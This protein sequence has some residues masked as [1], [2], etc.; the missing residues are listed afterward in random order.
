[1]RYPRVVGSPDEF[2]ADWTAD[3][4]AGS[5]R[6]DPAPRGAAGKRPPSSSSGAV[7]DSVDSLVEGPGSRVG[8]YTL[9]KLLGEGGFG[10]VFLAEQEVPVRRTVA[11]KIIKLGMDTRQVVA[12]FEQ[13]RQAL[14]WMDHPNIAR[15][16]DA[17]ATATG[18]PFFVME[19]VKGEPIT[20]YC[21]RKKLSIPN[22]L[23][24]FMQ[25]CSAVQ[26][27]HTKGIIHRDLKPGN[28]LASTQ[29]GKP[30]AKVIDFGVAK[31]TSERVKSDAVQTEQR[32]LVGTPL[33]MSPEQAAGSADIDTRTDIYSLGVVLYE[34][35]TG[36]TPIDLRTLR[37]TG[38]AQ[39]EKLICEHDPPR[40]SSRV[41]GTARSERGSEHEPSRP[42]SLEEVAARRSVDT[43]RLHSLV[44]GE[45]DWIVLRAM[46]K[47]RS[48]RYE[49]AAALAADLRRHLAGEPIQAAPPSRRYRVSKFVRRHRGGVGAAAAALLALLLGL[50]G[51]VWQAYRASDERDRAI[52]AQEAEARERSVAEAQRRAADDALAVAESQRDKAERI[53]EFMSD[54]LRGAGPSA[55][56]GRDITMLKEMMDRSAARIDA[57]ALRGSPES[58][59]QLRWT[60]GVTYRELALHADASRMLAPALSLAR[61]LHP[62]DHDEIAE[63]LGEIGAL[64]QAQG[65][66]A[67]A[68][69]SF[70]ESLAMM[71]RLHLGDHEPSAEAMGRLGSVLQ[72]QGSLGDAEPL[73]RESLAMN[74]RLHE[75][76]HPSVARSLGRMSAWHRANRDLPTAEPLARAS[77]EMYQRLHPGDHPDVAE[78]LHTMA[79]QLQGGRGFESAERLY[80][81]SLEMYRRLFDGDH[82]LIARGLNSLAFALQSR[83]DLVGSEPYL[84]ESVEMYERL[85]QDEHPETASALD[86]LAY[87]Q[88]QDG[89]W[90]A[91]VDSAR[92]AVAMYE[93][94]NGKDAG[95]TGSARLRLGHALVKLD[96]FQEAERELLEAERVLR[97]AEGMP[98]ARHR[99]S[100]EALSNLYRAW[101]RA[102]PGKGYD[103][104]ATEWRAK[105]PQRPEGRRERAP[106]QR[107]RRVSLGPTPEWPRVPDP[108]VAV[109][110][111]GTGLPVVRSERGHDS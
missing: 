1:M 92:E 26:H 66:L 95:V 19:F 68:R 29:D 74:Q 53:A 61:S 87:Q 12:R 22:R 84:R 57:G 55:A 110:D 58:E 101:D 69:D 78:S 8:P 30:H 59:L 14:A 102:E 3:L 49:S 21:D 91:A 20:S 82:P 28:I 97:T 39:L 46:E 48:R 42:S 43:R 6:E 4:N 75:G 109:V 93:R 90:A 40:P 100:E 71:R 64:H 23:W 79:F 83:G 111:L 85:F 72:S 9:K 70:A 5:G 108:G 80:R 51:T 41:G 33:T 36:S 94:T 17:G 11:L 56:R 104:K 54:A 86:N 35:L 18:R 105:K 15:V 106:G 50:A 47:D 89:N 65:D 60:I 10:S 88:S 32:Q 44:R 107:P 24:L 45:L 62:G 81:E 38:L 25:V 27:A 96:R 76:D 13:E 52:L 73:L 7:P 67:A 34:L 103:A 37:S 31:A 99:M 2:A 77:L 16:Y 98:P 63:I